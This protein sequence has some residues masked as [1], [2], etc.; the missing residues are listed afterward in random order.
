M[1]AHPRLTPAVLGL[2]LAAAA[3]AA[4]IDLFGLGGGEEPAPTTWSELPKMPEPADARRLKIH[5]DVVDLLSEKTGAPPGFLY[6]PKGERE[7]A[8]GLAWPVGAARGDELVRAERERFA[9]SGYALFLAE[10]NFGI[11]PDRIAVLP[12][13]DPFAPVLA[14]GTAGP[15]GA[16]SNETVVARL[17]EWRQETGL[18]LL[19][20]GPD[21]VEVELSR[22]PKDVDELVRETAALAPAA[23]GDDETSRERFTNELRRSRRLYL[24][25]R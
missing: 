13:T 25:W 21:W 8:I 1:R 23:V 9:K 4:G 12:A 20:A 7:E 18:E 3:P 11:A 24:W 14:L 6:G 5:E 15:D 10:R 19:G 16:T 17:R 2:F 22:L